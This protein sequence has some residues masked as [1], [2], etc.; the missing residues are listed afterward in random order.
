MKKLLVLLFLVCPAFAWAQTASLIGE[1]YFGDKAALSNAVY[2]LTRDTSAAL[3]QTNAFRNQSGN[4]VAVGLTAL[5]NPSRPKAYQLSEFTAQLKRDGLWDDLVWLQVFG[6]GYQN[7]SNNLVL[8]GPRTDMA[9]TNRNFAMSKMDRDVRTFTLEGT[10]SNATLFVAGAGGGLGQADENIDRTVLRLRSPGAAPFASVVN[11]YKPGWGTMRGQ[12]V[13][14]GSQTFYDSARTVFHSKPP[15]SYVFT[16]NATNKQAIIYTNAILAA[17]NT[18][19]HAFPNAMTTVDF[20][21]CPLN[22]AAAGIWRRPL[23]PNEV[24]ALENNLRRTVLGADAMVV[25]DG[26]SIL[27]ITAGPPYEN[28]WDRFIFGESDWAVTAAFADISTGGHTTAQTL[29]GLPSTLTP[30]TANGIGRKIYVI[31]A[32]TNDL[33]GQDASAL[34][35]AT[36]KDNLLKIWNCA[37]TNGCYVVG[38]TLLQ[39]DWLVDRP[40]SELFALNDW[41]RSQDGVALDAVLDLDAEFE[42]EVGPRYWLNTDYF[43]DAI[44]PNAP[45]QNGLR[46]MRDAA[47][48]IAW[49]VFP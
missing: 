26:D 11:I 39:R 25:I 2:G 12:T 47:Q 44:H 28:A 6:S 41:I 33:G 8:R 31:D 40:Y 36:V 10:Y 7:A 24:T 23:T 22:Y 9:G 20:G 27:G 16:H 32:G 45:S 43:S 14:G 18:Y 38:T 37:K 17:S 3:G 5:A 13:G 4:A 35:L 46:V 42:R 30:Y 21:E 29:A 49:K 48:R 34:P 15:I 19:S 1:N